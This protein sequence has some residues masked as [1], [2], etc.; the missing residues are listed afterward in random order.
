MI[1]PIEGGIRK[2]MSDAFTIKARMKLSLYPAL[3]I[4]GRNGE[5]MA[6]TVAWVEPDTAPNIVQADAVATARPPRR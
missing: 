3:S 5:P 6:T 4:R 2:A 1:I